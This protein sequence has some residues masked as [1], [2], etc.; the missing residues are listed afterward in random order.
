MN[1]IGMSI[2]ISHP[3]KLSIEEQ[4]KVFAEI[5]F[6]SFFL[7]CGVTDEYDRIPQWA[8]LAQRCGIVFEAVHA[9]SD[10]MNAVWIK[11]TAGDAY[12]ARI[13]R[14]VEYCS[15]GGV[16]KLVMH[17]SGG[18]ALPVNSCGLD[19]YAVLETRA[20]SCGVRLCYEN[21]DRIDH[22]EA[23]LARS[24]P[25]HGFCYDCGHEACYTLDAMLLKKWGNRLLYTHLHDNR[26]YGCGDLHWMPFDGVCDWAVLATGFVSCGYTGTLNLELACHSN[27]A[28]GEMPYADFVRAAKDRA[29]RFGEML[30]NY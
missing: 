8:E 6:D 18:D 27:A 21:G 5:G 13:G 20:K 10:G 14:I 28:Y 2:I 7:S 26:G 25:F 15:D 24:D 30:K 11:D 23:V 9:P 19:R 17:V 4:I 29:V 1:R 12:M 16:E 22:L 3:D